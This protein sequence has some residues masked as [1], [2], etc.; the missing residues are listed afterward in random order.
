MKKW[1]GLFVVTMVL[2]GCELT[3]GSSSGGSS[4]NNKTSSSKEKKSSSKS[5]SKVVTGGI[6][7]SEL[8]DALNQH[9]KK[10][11]TDFKE[12][13]PTKE[14]IEQLKS[15]IVKLNKKVKQQDAELKK[16]KDKAKS[17]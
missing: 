4:T 15:A 13:C 12:N 11:L 14:T 6:S 1:L 10:L 3:Q 9:N 5:S 16:Y 17:K 2:N 8:E 7:S